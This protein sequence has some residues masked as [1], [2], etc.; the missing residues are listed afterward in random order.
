L[1]HFV[2]PRI[3]AEVDGDWTSPAMEMLII[4]MAEFAGLMLAWLL[5]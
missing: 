1:K 3:F 4:A 5:L 2:D